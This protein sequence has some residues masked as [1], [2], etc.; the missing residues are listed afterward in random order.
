MARCFVTRRLPGGALER[1]EREHEV[2]LWTGDLPPTPA[3]LA[4]RLHDVEGLLCLLTDTVD[5]RLIEAAPKL[6]AVATYSVGSDNVD[7]EA[8]A[9]RGIAV[10][11]TPDVLT[12]AT[13]DMAFALM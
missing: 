3:E 11:V 9:E 8:A 5:R 1:L 7:L 4:A 2:R 6:R 10:G 13:A 12:D